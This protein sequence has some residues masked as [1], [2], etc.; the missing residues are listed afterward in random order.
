MKY[1]KAPPPRVSLG[2]TGQPVDWELVKALY[3]SGLSPKQI[4][5]QT[6]AKAHH[7]SVRAT[8]KQWR[9]LGT[10]AATLT[11][12]SMGVGALR[13]SHSNT[14]H[15]LGHALAH[16]STLARQGLSEEIQAGIDTLKA[17][18][19]KRQVKD[20]Q[21]RAG[22]TNTLSQAAKTVYG[23][24]DTGGESVVRLEVLSAAIVPSPQA[25]AIDVPTVPDGQLA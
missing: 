3:I 12:Q 11:K 20:I 25:P 24:Q 10:K 23:W 6:G 1:D 4:E 14:P 22:A 21:A 17:T 9:E 19:R 15:L 5:V 18:K 13:V 16:A 8:R 7:V 2:V